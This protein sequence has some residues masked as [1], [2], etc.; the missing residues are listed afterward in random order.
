MPEAEQV[1][2][3]LGTPGS[4]VTATDQLLPWPLFFPLLG[5]NFYW[6]SG[7]LLDT[8]EGWASPVSTVT[9]GH[10]GTARGPTRQLRVSQNLP[11]E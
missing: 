4:L 3:S 11:W 7:H 6:G 1:V 9:R 10:E 8:G 2:W 5:K